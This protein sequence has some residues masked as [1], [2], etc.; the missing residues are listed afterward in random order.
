MLIKV[1]LIIATIIA[2]MKFVFQLIEGNL[3][4]VSSSGFIMLTFA[5]VGRMVF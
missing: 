5:W 1:F 3:W 2:T 4:D